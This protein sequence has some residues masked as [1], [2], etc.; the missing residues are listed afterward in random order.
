[1]W[2]DGGGSGSKKYINRIYDKIK[3]VLAVGIE[4][5]KFEFIHH[6]TLSISLLLFSLFLLD[7]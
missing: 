5:N 2:E 1:M 7:Q 4:P 3:H 6:Y